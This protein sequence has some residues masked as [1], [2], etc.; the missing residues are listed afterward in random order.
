M[1]PALLGALL[2]GLPDAVWLV[3]PD[4]LSILAVNAA[5]MQLLGMT[6]EAL[7]GRPVTEL[8]PAPEDIYF[9]DDVAAGRIDQISSETRIPRGDGSSLQVERRV[10]LLPLGNGEKIYVVGLRDLTP[11]RHVEDRL[12]LVLAEMQATLE[13]TVDGILACSLEGIVTVCN[14]RFAELWSLPEDL[15]IEHNDQA[16]FAHMGAS[17]VNYAAYRRRMDH[18][19]TTPMYQGTDILL[20]NGGRVLERV[21]RPQISQGRA[22]GRVYSF[23]DI[24]E[25]IESEAQLQL[26]GKV[27]E[28]SLDAIFIADTQHFL[29]AVNPGCERLSRCGEDVL[30]GQSAADLFKDGDGSPLFDR[31]QRGWQRDGH[32]DGEALHQRGDGSTCV[33]HLSWVA[34]RDVHG[35]VTQSIGFFK[36]L[37]EKKASHQRIEQ[38]AY[39]DVLTGLPNRLNLSQRVD[40][41]LRLADRDGGEFAVLFLDLDRFKNIN[42]SLGHLFGDRV[43]VEVSKRMQACL[44]QVDTL[45]R[46]GGDEFVMYLHQA[47]AEGAKMVAQRV[48]ESLEQPFRLDDVDFSVGCSI[49][50]AMFPADG[51]TLDDM[52]K[53]ADTAMNRV[54]ER[55]RGNFRFYQPQMNVELLSRMKMEHSMR[56]AMDAGRFRLHY[57]PQVCLETG[58]VLGVEALIRWFDPE[59]GSVPPGRFIPLAE[60]S[61]YIVTIGTWVLNEAVR[62]AAE[63]QQQGYARTVS[64][65]VSALQFQQPDFVDRVALVLR[66]SGLDPTLLE[67]ELTESILVQD[68]DEALARLQAL[69]ALGVIL[70]IDDFGTGYSSLAYLKKFPIHKLKI[71]RSFIRGLPADESDQAIVSAIIQMGRALKLTVIA[72]GVETMAQRDVLQHLHCDQ[73]QGFLCS[74]GV[75]SDE[76]ENVIDLAIGR[77]AEP[78]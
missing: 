13:S 30:L 36:D 3:S 14:R 32:W 25:R 41:A 69:A 1:I 59:L 67:L 61:G 21:T 5:A 27:F 73:Y 4:D 15:L 23:R 26:A 45:C 51:R 56:Q 37:T 35:Q 66:T 63:W 2:E 71:D 9:W 48:L 64:V 17:V 50:V 72:E 60:E 28:S 76:L 74:P 54:K 40:F 58:N 70:S 31:I 49:G 20:L 62:Q 78:C 55:G 38:L 75:P 6:R 53:S 24:T 52:I 18:I 10:S 16:L 68:A 29:V 12:E 8:T 19:I 42:D 47:D 33:V 65:N 7:V 44:R 57:Q 77:L 11:L 46:L 43:L 39:T 22:I 34:L